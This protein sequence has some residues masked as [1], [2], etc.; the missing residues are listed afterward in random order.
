MRWDA[1][2]LARVAEHAGFV[3]DDVRTAVAVALA[4]SG[5]MDHYRF[6]P[7]SPG[8]GDYHGL[9]GIDTDRYPWYSTV[10]LDIPA[11]NARCARELCAEHWGWRWSP[12]WEAGHWQALTDHAGVERTR[13][14]AGQ[15]LER[16][17]TLHTSAS[18]LADTLARVRA[19]TT[20]AS[21]FRVGG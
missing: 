11:E 20:A 15:A 1:H 9:W 14:Y 10:R 17:M 3:G 5:G 7:G 16:P 8:S 13:T 12:V 6:R 21:S 2:Q 4:T 18:R 19:V